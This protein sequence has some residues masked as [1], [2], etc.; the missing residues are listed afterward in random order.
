MSAVNS[1]QRAADQL[2]NIQVYLDGDIV[3]GAVR[4][5]SVNS[6]LSGSFNSVNRV[7]RFAGLIAE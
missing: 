7:G 5:S 6:S 2:L 4:N 3:G 1:A